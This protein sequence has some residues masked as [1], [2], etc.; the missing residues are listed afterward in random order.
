[1]LIHHGHQYSCCNL[2]LQHYKLTCILL[3]A[4][5]EGKSDLILT[6]ESWRSHF[7]NVHNLWTVMAFVISEVGMKKVHMNKMRAETQFSHRN[8]SSQESHS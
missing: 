2:K 5:H 8:W 6:Q 3:C 7:R 1:M 4:T